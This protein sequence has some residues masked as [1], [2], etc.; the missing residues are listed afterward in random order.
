MDRS[1]AS[2]NTRKRQ[3]VIIVKGFDGEPTSLAVVKQTAEGV[4]AQSLT[5]DATIG[6]WN[7]W[8]YR[9]DEELLSALTEAYERSDSDAL[10]ELWERAEPLP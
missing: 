7:A 1:P 5:T 9:W 4:V 3:A 2:E 10:S 8:I 6:L